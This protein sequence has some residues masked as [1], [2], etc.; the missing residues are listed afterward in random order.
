MVCAAGCGTGL[1]SAPPCLYSQEALSYF[2]QPEGSSLTHGSTAVVVG[3]NAF[4]NS[5]PQTLEVLVKPWGVDTAS[6]LGSAPYY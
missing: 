2:L 1:H 6:T 5:L 3:H 4:V